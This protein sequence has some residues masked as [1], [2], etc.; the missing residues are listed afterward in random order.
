[1]QRDSLPKN[2]SRKRVS[3][4]AVPN[5]MTDPV[6][7]LE[8]CTDDELEN[9]LARVLVYASKEVLNEAEVRIFYQL[10][11]EICRRSSGCDLPRC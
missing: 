7:N 3:A 5:N 8:T 10:Y 1:V 11:K 6:T 9:A 4:I 2:R